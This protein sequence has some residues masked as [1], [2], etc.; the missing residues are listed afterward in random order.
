MAPRERVHQLGGPRSIVGPMVRPEPVHPS[1]GPPSIAFQTE[2]PEPVLRLA[3]P[4]SIAGP[5]VRPEPVRR[6]GGPPSTIGP[7]ARPERVPVSEGLPSTIERKH[8]SGTP[9][10]ALHPRY[11][12]GGIFYGNSTTRIRPG[13]VRSGDR[14]TR[15]GSFLARAG[16]AADRSVAGANRCAPVGVIANCGKRG[17]RIPKG[18]PF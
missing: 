11:R 18:T 8:P 5:M 13:P 4:P 12:G 17:V 3:V 6:L 1:G 15:G 10:C 16:Q 2:G 7:M 9:L 14:R